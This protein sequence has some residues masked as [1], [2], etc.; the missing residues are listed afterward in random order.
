MCVCSLEKCQV[1]Q[2][3]IAFAELLSL[4]DLPLSRNK[5]L[6]MEKIDLF[7]EEDVVEITIES[8]AE[9]PTKR[10]KNAKKAWKAEEEKY[11]EGFFIRCTKAE[12]DAIEQESESFEMSKSRFLIAKALHA[13]RVFSREEV[14]LLSNN[15]SELLRISNNANQIAK[16]LNLSRLR[17]ETI[18]LSQKQ[19]FSLTLEIQNVVAET[20]EKLT[21]LC[22]F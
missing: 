13:K 8:E 11:S 19:L 4:F 7:E 12:K 17:G 15:L 14:T 18:D 16:G 20:K 1:T 3:A 9:T 22:R 10:Q 2:I 5:E 6:L 21:K